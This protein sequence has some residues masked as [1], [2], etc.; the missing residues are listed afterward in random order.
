MLKG[1]F[2]KRRFTGLDVGSSSVK[3]I[4]LS[5]KGDHLTLT[6]LGSEPLALDTVIDGQ[7]IEREEMA[8][9]ISKLFLQHHLGAQRLATAIGG[10]PTILKTILLPPMTEEE[11]SESIDWHAEEHIPYEISDVRLSYQ[12]I[13]STEDSLSVMLAAC[14]KELL[15][16]LE[17]T[18]KLA[19]G[20]ADI[21]DFDA[22]A[23]EN[24]YTFNYQPADDSLVALVH[25]GASRMLIQI[26]KGHQHKFTRD[27]SVGGN[28]YTDKIQRELGI[29]FEQAEA[30]K[31][32]GGRDLE[33]EETEIHEVVRAISKR[34]TFETDFERLSETTSHLIELEIKRTLDF[35]RATSDEEEPVQKI[36]ISGGGSKLKGLKEYLARSF[37]IAVE[38]LDPFRR[39]KFNAERFDSA[40]LRD[41]AP[42]MAVAVGLAL[43]GST[44]AMMKI[45]L[46]K[47]AAENKRGEAS[48]TKEPRKKW[49]RETTKTYL[50]KGRN[51]MGEIVIGER[52]AE[53]VESLQAI[54]RRE[55]IILTSSYEESPK[56]FHFPSV[57]RQKK[58]SVNELENFTRWYMLL[59]DMGS[60][61]LPALETI[62]QEE[63][64]EYFRQTL[65]EIIS[66]VEQGSSLWEAMELHPKVFDGYFVN[67]F[68]AGEVC[69]VYDRVLPRLLSDLERRIELRRRIKLAVLYPLSLLAVAII[70][71]LL[72]MIGLQGVPGAASGQNLSQSFWA[73]VLAATGAFL[74]S[75]GGII[76]LA[77][78][79]VT[80]SLDGRLEEDKAWTKAQRCSA[81]ANPIF[82]RVTT[83]AR[84]G[85]LR[86]HAVNDALVRRADYG[87]SGC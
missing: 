39:I 12:I 13:D 11:L 36:L 38:P 23:L 4:E 47:G 50:Y 42:E 45:N 58:V 86:A 69:V 9:A 63:K 21:I 3:A 74:S 43:R 65:D 7:I 20:Q 51:R 79:I 10:Y 59:L 72:I 84:S 29:T 78:I 5:G 41:V 81:F 82:R 54:L 48:A 14:K 87:V 40:R 52:A 61:I 27:A 1:L 68:Q 57:R 17:Q 24:C 85:T 55:Q 19:G 37:E 70:T 34:L 33:I 30:A 67:L 15:E 28:Q 16:N 71:T 75:A 44:A 22:L 83:Q 25:I 60:P 35:H 62:A 31:L 76:I 32:G 56:P 46:A 8:K 2:R 18:I 66:D 77:V 6:G 49:R 64:N 26:V 53:N 80:V 73:R